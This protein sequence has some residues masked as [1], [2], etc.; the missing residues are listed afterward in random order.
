MAI[1]AAVDKT[2]RAE[3][4]IK[5]ADI[6]AEKFD[7]VVHVVHVMKRSEVVEAEGSA[8]TEE[9]V[10]IDELRSSATEVAADLI[11]SSNISQKSEAVG[12]IGSPA[13]EVVDYAA[14]QKAR[15][16]V[17]SPQRK[18]QTG[19]IL[20]GSVAQSILLNATCPV[21]SLIND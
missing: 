5:E 13:S 4:V 3:D 6:L 12:L 14:D 19:K 21:V 7:D 17:V 8:N 16:I 11:E 15:Y 9:A 18:S 20:F 1:V 10:S 2:A